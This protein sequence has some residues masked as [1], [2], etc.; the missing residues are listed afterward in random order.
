MPQ[1][2]TLAYS[3]L[4]VGILSGA[5]LAG[6]LCD[7][8][9]SMVPAFFASGLIFAVAALVRGHFCNYVLSFQFVIVDARVQ[10]LNV[11]MF[12]AKADAAPPEPETSAGMKQ[13]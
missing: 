12:Q 11:D 10:V 9:G 13:P 8:T 3:S 6:L 4:L 7:A 1:A 5:P 2:V